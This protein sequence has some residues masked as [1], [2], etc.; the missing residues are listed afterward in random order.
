MLESFYRRCLVVSREN[1]VLLCQ[2]RDAVVALAHSS[3]LSANGVCLRGVQHAASGLIDI[4]EVDLDRCVVLGV[5][6]SVAGRAGR[7]IVGG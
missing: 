4:N 1:T 3:D 2:T 6:D 5:D 7:L